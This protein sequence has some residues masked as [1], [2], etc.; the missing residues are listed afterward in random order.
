MKL[1]RAFGFISLVFLSSVC[2][3][4]EIA[5]VVGVTT[6]LPLHVGAANS[7]KILAK[8]PL[9][10]Q[11][12]I[13]DRE[14]ASPFAK[15]EYD[16]P[17]AEPIIGYLKKSSSQG[18]YLKTLATV[19]T[20]IPAPPPAKAPA[21]HGAIQ[22]EV[23]SDTP[24]NVRSG[25]GASYTI[26]TALPPGGKVEVIA[27]NP[28]TGW[29]KVNT[30]PPGWVNGAYLRGPITMNDVLPIINQIAKAN[31]QVEASKYC[32]PLQETGDHCVTF[33]PE[34][35]SGAKV[36]NFQTEQQAFDESSTEKKKENFLAFILPLALHFQEL[37]GWPAS[38]F[39]AQVQLESN[40]GTSSLLGDG[41]NMTGVSC[42]THP[43]QTGVDD[44]PMNWTDSNGNKIETPKIIYDCTRS[45]PEGGN[46]RTY[47]SAL[48]W[49]YDYINIVLYTPS[50]SLQDQASRLAVKQRPKGG[51][52]DWKAVADGLSHY[53]PS[54]WVTRLNPPRWVS[55]PQKIASSMKSNE[56]TNYSMEKLCP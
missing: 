27:Q 21:T 15:V 29:D 35:Y 48:D 32:I 56:W 16:L 43:G 12:K 24:L 5:E 31:T 26:L 38:I 55:Y 45:R 53:A 22:A 1:K 17:G 7:T 13:L 52:A 47:T 44:D 8:I 6:E 49:A 51:V 3:A 14:G 37:T 30:N 36:K 40:W 42:L 9:H 33:N 11:V 4:D 18:S 19:E 50:N 2:F 34:N 23:V 39:L 28:A 46:Y 20:T 25:P 54:E 10:A 41:H